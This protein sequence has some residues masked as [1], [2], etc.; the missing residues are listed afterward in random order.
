MQILASDIVGAISAW[1]HFA[2]TIPGGGQD[3]TCNQTVMSG[4]IEDAI[5]DFAAFSFEFD[6][7]R[8]AL[9]GMF[10]V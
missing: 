4:R 2:A 9:V 7:V 3:S 5:V 6:R 8:C 10:L 1:A